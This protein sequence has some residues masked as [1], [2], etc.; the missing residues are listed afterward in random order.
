MKKN[1]NFHCYRFVCYIGWMPTYQYAC[2]NSHLYEES[3]GIREEQRIKD[4]PECG[5]PLKQKYHAP[6]IELKGGGFYRNTR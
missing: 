4:C 2:G 3:R 5:L 6:G 1:P